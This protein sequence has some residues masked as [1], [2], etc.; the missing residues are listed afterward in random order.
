MFSAANGNAISIVDV[1]AGSAQIQVTLAAANGVLSL[2][3]TSWIDVHRRS[4]RRK[5]A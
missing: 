2:A 4:R 1:D 3:Q 5:P